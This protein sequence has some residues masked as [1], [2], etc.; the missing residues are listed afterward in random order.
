MIQ[1][2]LRAAFFLAIEKKNNNTKTLDTA[3]FKPINFKYTNMNY[4]SRIEK[5]TNAQVLEKRN[6]KKSS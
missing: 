3:G 6:G 2:Q 4:C 1:M 5:V